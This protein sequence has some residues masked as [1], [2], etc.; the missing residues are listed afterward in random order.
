MAGKIE[1]NCSWCGSTVYRYKS[2]IG[3][4]IFCCTECRS[5]F[6]SKAKNPDGYIKHS[7]LTEYNLKHNP[8][9]MTDDV[10]SKLC[11]A[12]LGT[13]EGKAYKKLH[14]R[15]I[16]RIVAEMLLGRPL[17]PG[18][19]VH[20]IDGNKRNNRMTNLHVFKNQAEHAKYHA[21]T[22]RGDA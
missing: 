17:K 14:G 19:V 4:H 18:E 1:V 5:A 20:H 21:N 2:A 6:L 22:K 16:H 12:R 15:H 3:K 7:H 9:R 11:L 13:G 8:E 10:R